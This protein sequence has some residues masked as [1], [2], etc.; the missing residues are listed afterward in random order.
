MLLGQRSE[1]IDGLKI[2]R[3]ESLPSTTGRLQRAI[4]ESILNHCARHLKEIS[5][6]SLQERDRINSTIDPEVIS[7][8]SQLSNLQKRSECTSIYGKFF[9]TEQKEKK[10]KLDWTTRFFTS[11]GRQ[12][13]R[14]I[15]S[16]GTTVIF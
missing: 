16:L 14:A 6:A 2:F 4:R 1:V 13:C 10:E 12:I 3:P 7:K 15:P 11:Q 8:D 9:S 5:L